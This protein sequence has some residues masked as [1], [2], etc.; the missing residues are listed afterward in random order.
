[1]DKYQLTIGFKYQVMEL[2]EGQKFMGQSYPPGWYVYIVWQDNRRDLHGPIPDET[3]ANALVD[4]RKKML[5][6][7][8]DTFGKQ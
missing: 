5:K 6:Q 2:L 7:F 3:T 4:E 8:A 1:M